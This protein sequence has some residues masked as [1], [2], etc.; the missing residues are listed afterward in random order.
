MGFRL[1]GTPFL[2][3]LFCHDNEARIVTGECAGLPE[4]GFP[5]QADGAFVKVCHG[6]AV[7]CG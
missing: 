3:F 4:A 6:E 2:Y 7:G 5:V 1:S